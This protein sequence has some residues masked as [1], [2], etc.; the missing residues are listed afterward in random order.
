MI[1]RLCEE[2]KHGTP[3]D[4]DA[5][6]FTCSGYAMDGE[7]GVLA[8]CDCG[9]HKTAD[10]RTEIHQRACKAAANPKGKPWQ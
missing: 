7:T 10:E 8:P 3:P 2:G 1:G 5:I 9:C 6:P 4:A